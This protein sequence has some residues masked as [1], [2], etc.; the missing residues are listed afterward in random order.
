MYVGRKYNF[1]FF[2]PLFLIK[3]VNT[4]VSGA[5]IIIFSVNNQQC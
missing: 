1:E 5:I 3:F 2:L 4:C